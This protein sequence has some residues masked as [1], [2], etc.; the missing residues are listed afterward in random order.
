[1]SM[2]KIAQQQ[3]ARPEQ[4]NMRN[5]IFILFFGDI[6][7]ETNMR[8]KMQMPEQIWR[9]NTRPK[10]ERCR[11]DEAQGRGAGRKGKIYLVV[12][13]DM[14]TRGPNQGDDLNFAISFD[15]SRPE[16]ND[17]DFKKKRKK[18]IQRRAG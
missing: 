5:K 10:A 18:R 8:N 9:K 11:S 7:F 1:M 16:Y 14:R 12:V 13:E 6:F 15:L 2:R 4:E 17:V 3:D